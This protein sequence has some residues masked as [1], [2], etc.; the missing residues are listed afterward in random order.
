MS[1]SIFKVWGERRRLLL[2][3]Q[4]EID[5]LYLK[6]DHFCSTHN[7]NDKINKFFDADPKD[8]IVSL[9]LPEVSIISHLDNYKE[10][11]EKESYSKILQVERE[12]K[13]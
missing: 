12:G 1:D 13:V 9:S 10:K 6:K 8:F 11:Q 7:H 3:D 4:T 2:I 5:L